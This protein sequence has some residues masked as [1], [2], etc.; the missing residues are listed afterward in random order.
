MKNEIKLWN[1]IGGTPRQ[2]R[3]MVINLGNP[4]QELIFTSV[5]KKTRQ[6]NIYIWNEIPND[7]VTRILTLEDS[8]K[9]TVTVHINEGWSYFEC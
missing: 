7:D 4:T 2:R 8:L 3:I 9:R 5:H 1:G 6:L